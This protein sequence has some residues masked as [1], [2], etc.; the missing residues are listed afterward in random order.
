MRI[1]F[2]LFTT[3]LSL[4]FVCSVNGQEKKETAVAHG[5]RNVES[6]AYP[7]KDFTYISPRYDRTGYDNSGFFESYYIRTVYTMK[8]RDHFRLDLP[9]GRSNLTPDGTVDFGLSDISLRFTQYVF[10]TGHWFWG[11][12]IKAV[13]PT[14]TSDALGGGKWQLHPGVGGNYYFGE[15]DDKGSITLAAE[16]RFSVA[17]DKD[18][19]NISI[20][21]F[22][23][24]IDI[25]RPR[26]Y[27][28]YYATWTYNFQTDYFDL[29]LDVEFGY[30][31]TSRFV[32]S[33]EGIVPLLKNA[34][35]NY[36]FSFKLRYAL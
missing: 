2:I 15:N 10:E 29:P 6:F 25:W 36:E 4:F 32:I 9:L 8:G 30:F 35:Y 21:A 16:Y 12:A 24:N 31:L 28:G 18:R 1:L 22:I 3:C 34:P 20:L 19:D 26:W 13:F 5:G 14:A 11:Y 7:Y 27:L 23:P 33:A 17:G